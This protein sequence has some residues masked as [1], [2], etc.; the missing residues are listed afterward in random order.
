M[1]SLTPVCQ[2]TSCGLRESNILVD[3]HD[4]VPRKLPAD[5]GVDHADAAFGPD[6]L[7]LLLEARRVAM[8]ASCDAPAPDVLDDP[9]ATMR[10][11]RLGVHGG[12]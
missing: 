5:A 8:G 1:A 7:Q 11:R 4:H 10:E 9:S 12:E 2:I 6:R 3:A